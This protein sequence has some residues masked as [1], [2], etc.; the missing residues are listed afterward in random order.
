MA[1]GS[2]KIRG[3]APSTDYWPGFVDAMSS[4]LLVLIFLLT[5]FMITQFFL[6]QIVSNKD[7][8]LDYLKS[9]IAELTS[10]LA[11][12]KR[13]KA[14]LQSTIASLQASLSAANDEKN[15]LSGMLADAKGSGDKVSALQDRLDKQKQISD[16]ALQQVALL[17]EQIAAMRHQLAQLQASLDA[18]E[19]KDEE[20][21]A[22]I[23]NLGKRLNAALAQKVQELARYRSD[24]FGRLRKILG[25]RKD[26][27]VV[28][29]RFVMQSEIFF[30]SGSADLSPEGNRELTQIADAV[31]QIAKDI[32]AD[33]PWVLR[34]DGHTDANPINTPEFPS[35]WELSTARALKVVHLLENEGVPPKR[36]VAAGFGEYQP[37]VKGTSP[38]ANR[39]NRRIEFKLTER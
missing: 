24:F 35:N 37:L 17:N 9:Q 16:D 33:I 38:E 39:R 4:L 29:D 10:Q 22:Q 5:I 30:D 31:K 32:P 36:L 14:D 26:I 6:T 15:R 25:D 27:E 11:V 21:Q 28:G 19:K 12:S 2:R 1:I 7:S 34:V 8:A 13:E 18:A 20:S 23:A 3:R